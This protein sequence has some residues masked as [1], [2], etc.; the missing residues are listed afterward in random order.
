MLSAEALGTGICRFEVGLRASVGGGPSGANGLG[1]RERDCPR[2]DLGWNGA[3]K[4]L[5]DH[6][7]TLPHPSTVYGGP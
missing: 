7:L 5:M 2:Q 1:G 4:F 6:L 3:G